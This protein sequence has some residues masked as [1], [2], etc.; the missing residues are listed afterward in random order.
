MMLESYPGAYGIDAARKIE[1]PNESTIKAVLGKSHSGEAILG[2]DRLR[3]FDTYH[4]LFKLGS[5]PSAH[6]EALSKL[7]NADLLAGLPAVLGRIV[8]RISL[9]LARLPE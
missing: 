3:L 2:S 1:A 4:Q 9:M 6:L 8:N 7:D 5:K